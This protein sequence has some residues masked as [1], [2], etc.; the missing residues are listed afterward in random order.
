MI[1]IQQCFF[2]NDSMIAALDISMSGSHD[3]CPVCS[4]MGKEVSA[5]IIFKTS[6]VRTKYYSTIDYRRLCSIEYDFT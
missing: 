4:Y 6:T 2:F 5:T 3:L 1:V